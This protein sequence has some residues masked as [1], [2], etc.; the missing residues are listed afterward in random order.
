MEDDICFY[1]EEQDIEFC[2][3]SNDSNDQFNICFVAQWKQDT[4]VEFYAARS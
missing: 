2:W 3:F 4:H 1:H